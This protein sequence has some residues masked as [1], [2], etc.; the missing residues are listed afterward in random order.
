[1]HFIHWG[2]YNRFK[3]LSTSSGSK[4]CICDQYSEC[5]IERWRRWF[6]LQ[7]LPVWLASKGYM[8]TWQA[9]GHSLDMDDPSVVHHAQVG[10]D[11]TR[12]ARRLDQASREPGFDDMPNEEIPTIFGWSPGKT[13]FLEPAEIAMTLEP[14]SDLVLQ[15]HM[16]PT[17]R[18]E[19]VRAQIGL[20]F[21][22]KPKNHWWPGDGIGVAFQK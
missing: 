10:L 7:F 15:L 19:P 16:L 12:S 22:E 21:A 2:H 4:C 3:K 13:P 14:G 11:R 6:Y 18:R 5:T 1:M 20:F 9:C 8:F 17:G